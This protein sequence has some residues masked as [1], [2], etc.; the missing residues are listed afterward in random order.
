MAFA[1]GLAFSSVFAADSKIRL[2]IPAGSLADGISA[3]GYQAHIFVYYGSTTDPLKAVNLRVQSVVGDF[4]LTE[5]LTRMLEGT[6]LTFQF[7]SPR[8]VLIMPIAEPAPSSIHE[9]SSPRPQPAAADS[10]PDDP[11]EVVVTGSFI[12]GLDAITAPLIVVG[13]NEK[14]QAA[15]GTVQDVLRTLPLNFGGGAGEDFSSNQNFS[16]GSGINLRGLGNGATLVLVDG[17][18]QPASGIAGDFVDVSTIPWSAV[19]RIEIVADGASALYGSDAIAGVVNIIMRQDLSGV[20]ESQARLGAALGGGNEKLMA[21]TL[22]HHWDGG[23]W[24]ATY[25]YSERTGLA[26]SERSY[27]GNADKRPLGGSDLRTYFSNPG[28]ILDPFTLQ[29]VFAIPAGQNGRPLTPGELLPGRVNL[30]NQMAT[31]DLLPD[32]KNHSIYFTG[33]QKLAERL[34][35]FVDARYNLRKISATERPYTQLIAVPSTNPFFIDPLGGSYV[36]VAYN[37]LN[38]FGPILDAADT[39]SYTGTLGLKLK[40]SDGWQ[41]TLSG[42]YGREEMRWKG[43]NLVDPVA[44]L[45]KIGDPDPAIAF[46][47]FA[48]GSNTSATTLEAIRY[49]QIEHAISG[50]KTLNLTADGPLPALPAGIPKLALGFDQ[51][52]ESLFRSES[53]TRD[54][55]LSGEYERKV[56]AAFAELSVPLLKRLNLSLATR[57]E[58]YSDFGNTFNLKAGLRWA[59][60]DSLR[61]RSS[62]GSSFRAPTL[63]DLYD[64]SLDAAA[65]APIADPHS[66]SGHSLVLLEQGRNPNL[67]EETARTWTAGVDL[68]PHAMPGLTLTSTY[69]MINYDN[70]TWRIQPPL[71]LES[72]LADQEWAS[73]VT[74]HPPRS[75]IEGIC[76]SPI[77]QGSSADCLASSPDLI[78][79]LRVRNLSATAVKGI[80]LEFKQAL[81]TDYGRFNFGLNGSYVLS[82]EQA[83]TRTAPAVD[84]AG[85]VLSPSRLRFRG[86][87]DW[88]RRGHDQPGWGASLSANYYSSSKDSSSPLADRIAA[89]ATFDAQL[90]YRTS[91]GI[92]GLSN[93]QLT[94]NAIDVFNQSPPFINRE[95]GYDPANAKPYGRVISLTMEK[96]W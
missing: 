32:R 86:T 91:E 96:A 70:R 31:I 79:D 88:N 57:Y 39:T 49:T 77:F 47:P 69:Y 16:R 23:K 45:N 5:A 25:Q 9:T 19:D 7:D 59:A 68:A 10:K 74:R 11:P 63:V 62:W 42:Y 26:A 4:D 37:F 65:L 60:N 82:F 34:D 87:T 3:L 41:T 80:D 75:E 43:Y 53:Q 93:I 83:V 12:R 72:L 78:L 85:T 94:L 22:G 61:F 1:F 66:P 28:N 17:R 20:A 44:I 64:P 6:G 8:G 14:K 58:T 30:Y 50:I 36:V 95:Q 71:T 40:M 2:N 33:S 52:L 67:H 90:N 81:Q 76:R 24:L 35:L 84:I 21:Q 54:T 55:S 46:N 18:R 56:E 13:Q 38:E 27:A 51:R 92:G 89:S 29:P 73:L 15:Y 48:W